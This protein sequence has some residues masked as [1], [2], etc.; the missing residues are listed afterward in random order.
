MRK[1]PRILVTEGTGTLSTE[2]TVNILHS[3]CLLVHS[4]FVCTI[5]NHAWLTIYCED[6]MLECSSRINGITSHRMVIFKEFLIQRFHLVSPSNH[7]NRPFYH[8]CCGGLHLLL[9]GFKSCNAWLSFVTS[10]QF[11]THCPYYL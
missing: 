6:G 9:H 10:L 4:P 8:I 2:N 3:L 5:L 11:S 1:K 7:R